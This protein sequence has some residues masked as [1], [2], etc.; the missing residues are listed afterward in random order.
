[1]R[2]Q[3]HE[4]YEKEKFSWTSWYEEDCKNNQKYGVNY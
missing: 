3:K 1:M 2:L 4:K